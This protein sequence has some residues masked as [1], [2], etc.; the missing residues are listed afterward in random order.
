MCACL[1]AVAGLHDMQSINR[2]VLVPARVYAF[3]KHASSGIRILSQ[4]T[5]R[6]AMTW[7]T[8]TWSTWTLRRT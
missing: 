5:T 6:W 8:P 7:P 1:F 4:E 3:A 2:V